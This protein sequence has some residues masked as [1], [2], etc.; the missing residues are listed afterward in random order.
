MAGELDIRVTDEKGKPVWTRLEVRGPGDK[1]FQARGAIVDKT[2]GKRPGG[3]PWYLGSFVV[4]GECKVE[5]PSGRYAVIA[6]HGPEYL[7]AEVNVDVSE[8]PKLVSIRLKPWIRMRERGWWSGDMHVH[9]LPED[10]AALAQ[11]EDLNVTVLTTMWNKRDLWAGKPL[12]DSVIQVSPNHLV[13]LRN[14]EDERGGGAW[15][16]NSLS[17]RLA[18]LAVDGRWYPPGI[19]FVREARAQKK[20]GGVLPWFDCEKPIWWEVP[21]MMALEPPDSFGVLHNHFNQYGIH[22]S[23]AWGRPRDQNKYP[24]KA[25]FVEYVVGLYY[26][27]LNLGFRLPP[28]AGSASG[29]L[30]GPVGYSRVYARLPGALSREAWYQA[31][32][33]GQVFV[34]NGPMLFF[35]TKQQGSRLKATVEVQAREPIDR[36]E[37]IANGKVVQVERVAGEIRKFRRDFVIDAA[38]YSWIAARCFVRNQW[39]IRMAHSAPVYLPG[40]YDAS[41]DAQY[42]IGWMDE[43]IAQTGKDPKQ[44]ATDSERDEVLALYRKARAFYQQ[45]LK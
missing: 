5:V 9:R 38:N 16:L 7:R 40:N 37:L 4:S 8:G 3:V 23:E 41:A 35:T 1:M 36:V 17:E 13:T 14:A 28:S 25:G 39:T 15:M 19:A 21:V 42:F 12:P 27:Y 32:R 43:L 24:D 26:R 45:K 11:A 30:P 34:T 22:D 10:A 18:N 44:F 20:A 29:V 33:D 6:E 31:L 2:A